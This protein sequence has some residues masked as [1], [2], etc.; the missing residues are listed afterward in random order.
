MTEADNA[1]N[2]NWQVGTRITSEGDVIQIT[3]IGERMVLGKY[4]KL[5]GSDFDGGDANLCLTLREW[6]KVRGK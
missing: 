4:L 3:A 5:K 2:R 1:R 6:R